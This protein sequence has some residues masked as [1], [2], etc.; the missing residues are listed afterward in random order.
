MRTHKLKWPLRI[1]CLYIFQV[2]GIRKDAE[3]QSSKDKDHMALQWWSQKEE[4]I[5]YTG[6]MIF[7]P[8]VTFNLSA[9]RFFYPGAFSDTPEKSADFFALACFSMQEQKLSVFTLV[10][11]I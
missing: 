7:P 10:S 6:D 4:S 3:V 9:N 11:L 2:G 8:P 5:Y 1:H